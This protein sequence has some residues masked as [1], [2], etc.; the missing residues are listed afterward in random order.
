MQD[1]KGVWLAQ[2]QPVAFP[3]GLAQ[4]PASLGVMEVSL[5]VSFINGSVVSV[6][7]EQP[8]FEHVLR[9]TLYAT[10]GID[11]RTV[12]L[13]VVQGNARLRFG[14]AVDIAEA[15]S[16]VQLPFTDC[17]RPALGPCMEEL[18]RCAMHSRFDEVQQYWIKRHRLERLMRG[19]RDEWER[20]DEDMR[21]QVLS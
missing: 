9:S 8:V 18:L 3:I 1:K 2:G 7:L 17:G 4:R 11:D 16:V 15:V 13:V 10:T 21:G 6:R 20:F 19:G 5:R 12:N 14:D